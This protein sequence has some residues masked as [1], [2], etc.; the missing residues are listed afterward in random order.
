MGEPDDEDN[1]EDDEF[2]EKAMYQKA[3]VSSK[4][5]G[6]VTASSI[7]SSAIDEDD[8]FDVNQQISISNR[9][10]PIPTPSSSSSTKVEGKY[11][12]A[13]STPTAVG[14]GD[15][16]DEGKD[17]DRQVTT[18]DRGDGGSGTG[19]G[20]GGSDG[21]SISYEQ[22]LMMPSTAATADAVDD[23]R[24]V[25]GANTANAVSIADT[26]DYKDDDFEKDEEE[27]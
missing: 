26:S 22:S 9:P 15:E 6:V 18:S 12:I 4:P 10:D 13:G 27:S 19:G 3:T 2:G 1:E 11:E 17:Q 24:V 7:T 5:K 8:V 25:A 23:E 16:S 14:A 21:V 20:D